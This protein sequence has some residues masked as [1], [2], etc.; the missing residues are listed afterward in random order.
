MENI[1][2]KALNR[3]YAVDLLKLFLCIGVLVS[4]VNYSFYGGVGDK[5]NLPESFIFL[6]K[7][8][9]SSL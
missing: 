7:I 8:F 2:N 3:N 4:H 1:S 5:S 6:Q 9:G